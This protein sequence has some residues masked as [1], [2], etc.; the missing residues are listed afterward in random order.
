MSF[1]ARKT[2][3]STYTSGIALDGPSYFA[4]LRWGV[5][6]DE[7]W[8]GIGGTQ[9]SAQ[10]LG[11][12]SQFSNFIRPAW[13]MDNRSDLDFTQYEFGMPGGRILDLSVDLVHDPASSKFVQTEEANKTNGTKRFV[14]V[15]LLG[16]AFAAPDA[17]IT[18]RVTIDMPCFHADDSMEERGQDQD[19]NLVVRAHFVSA[20]DAT[21]ALD[22]QIE[23]VNA[24]TSF[25]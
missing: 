25:P 8:A 13:Y 4:N 1:F 7:T 10:V 15:N 24:L 23:V 16:A 2:V 18:R 9:I 14:R 17:G 21:G 20:Y 11:F 3:D 12:T 6:V 22:M 5:H 19:G